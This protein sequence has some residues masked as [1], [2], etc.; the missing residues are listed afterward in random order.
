MGILGKAFMWGGVGV[1]I[2]IEW[3]YGVRDWRVC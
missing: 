1:E 2:G 3:G